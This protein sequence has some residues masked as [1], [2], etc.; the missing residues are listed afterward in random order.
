MRLGLRM[1]A[2]ALAAFA[3]Y[4]PAARAA[5]D[6]PPSSLALPSPM[7]TAALATPV[8]DASQYPA[9][10]APVTLA[11]THLPA[12]EFAGV[13]YRPRSHGY[14]R[15]PEAAGVSQLHVGF[16]DP[17]GDQDARLD[18]GVR[19][20]P[21]IDENL[22]LGLGVDWIHKTEN[23]SSVT[24][25]TTG[26][27]GV[28][29]EVKQDIARASVNMFPIMAFVQL[30]APDNLALIPYF[31]AGGGYQVLVLSGDDF[32]TGQSFDGTFS[33]WGWQV[34]GGL[35]L[36]LGGRTRLT[37]ELFVNGAEL[38]RDAT[39][40]VTG[41]TVHETVNAD[42]AGARFGVSWGF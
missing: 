6:L 37:G 9:P 19:G 42:G 7:V 10:Q 39:D 31:G 1:S 32:V 24:T 11:L 23:I 13:R 26:P 30:S 38:G 17:N 4:A 16:F 12:P 8:P 15:G 33:G 14:R 3:L 35:G 20:G 18:I 34:W 5:G 41:Q 36:P 22:Q 25:S 40:Q 29:I 21:M 2:A 28:P 27:G